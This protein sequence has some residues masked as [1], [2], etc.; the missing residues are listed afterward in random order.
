MTIAKLDELQRA[1]SD[2]CRHDAGCRELDEVHHHIL[3]AEN[4]F[5]LKH[6]G[7]STSQTQRCL[8]TK[9]TWQT[10]S[11][12][13]NAAAIAKTKDESWQDGAEKVWRKRV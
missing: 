11:K 8:Q 9:Y 13:D 6:V 10:R 5:D 3:D 2:P 1:T 7:I 12:S 4:I